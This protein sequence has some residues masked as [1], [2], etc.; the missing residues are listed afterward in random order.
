VSRLPQSPSKTTAWRRL[1]RGNRLPPKPPKPHRRRRTRRR[2]MAAARRAA[3]S[4]SRLGTQAPPAAGWAIPLTTTA[5]RIQ[6]MDP[7]PCSTEPPCTPLTRRTPVAKIIAR[8]LSAARHLRAAGMP[9]IH[10]GFLEGGTTAASSPRPA[11]ASNTDAVDAP[12]VRAEACSS[13]QR[14]KS[15]TCSRGLG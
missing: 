2:R 11:L 3:P 7:G 9:R 6:E 4:R 10:R 12:A 15:R 8:Q 1:R 13:V 14:P 5:T